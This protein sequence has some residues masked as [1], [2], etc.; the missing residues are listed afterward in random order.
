M[1]IQTINPYAPSDLET[2]QFLGWEYA[3]NDKALA[4]KTAVLRLYNIGAAVNSMKV[5]IETEDQTPTGGLIGTWSNGTTTTALPVS[6]D[7]AGKITNYTVLKVENEL[8]VVKSVD[9]VG[10]TIDVYKRGHG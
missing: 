10:N 2:K 3:L 8:V 9:R 5:E 7:L 1:G 6:A 4:L